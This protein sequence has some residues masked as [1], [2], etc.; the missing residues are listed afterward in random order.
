MWHP[1][2]LLGVLLA[3]AL[4]SAPALASLCGK[5]VALIGRAA[6][7]GLPKL[8]KDPTHLVVIG[9]GDVILKYYS[10]AFKQMMAD[11]GGPEH[12]K[13]TFL[14]NGSFSQGNPAATAKR[15]KIVSEI[16]AWGA[17]V[18]D[19]N[20]PVDEAKVRALRPDTVFVATPDH[21]HASIAVE[22]GE[23]FPKAKSIVL[24]KPV[25]A[26]LAAARA[27]AD[28]AHPLAGKLLGLDHTLARLPTDPQTMGKLMNHVG[29]QLKDFTFY[30]LEDGSG[31]DP[32][33]DKLVARDGAIEQAQRV[34]TL[35]GGMMLDLMPHV[36]AV[37]GYFG[38]VES[39]HVTSV[40]RMQYTGVDGDPNKRTEI[41]GE[42]LA[43][44][45]FTFLD[46]AGHT[47]SA[48]AHVGKGIR[49]VKALGPDYDHNVK[50]VDITG[51]NGNK[52]RL[53]LRSK[54]A[55]NSTAVLRTPDDKVADTLKLNPVPYYSLLRG[56]VTDIPTGTMPIGRAVRILEIIEEMRK[57]GEAQSPVMA[58][59]PGGMAGGRLA[60]YLEDTR[61][62]NP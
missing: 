2:R 38:K 8:V 19:R 36:L 52:E 49:G 13:V 5:E 17:K 3:F 33:G 7:P 62:T 57:L 12:V 31:A 40:K 55:G 18:L 24:E 47:V 60:P 50:V 58:T 35:D 25:E 28:P 41:K 34:R 4:F 21:T 39:I 1:Q 51:V 15:Q 56:S 20:D 43:T 14:D 45:Q 61:V 29:N 54:G 9:A 53:D 23:L 11:Y 16:E 30:F 26:D 6:A 42:T 27:L 59:Y 48:T 10:P 44:I 46:H 37:V 32:Y 22:A